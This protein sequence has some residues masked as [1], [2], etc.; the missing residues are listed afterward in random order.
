M[1][2]LIQ[3]RPNLIKTYCKSNLNFLIAL[4]SQQSTTITDALSSTD[5]TGT[6]SN[7]GDLVCQDIRPKFHEI[8][9]LLHK[10]L[11]LFKY[12]YSMNVLT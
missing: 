7:I 4:H 8:S 11:I 10:K 9:F 5:K 6:Y 2:I 3:K 1:Y 12:N